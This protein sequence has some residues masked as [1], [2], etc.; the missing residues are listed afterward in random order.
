MEWCLSWY[1]QLVPLQNKSH[2]CEFTRV[3]VPDSSAKLA[4]KH[5]LSILRVS[6]VIG[7]CHGYHIS[8]LCLFFM[9]LPVLLIAS[10]HSLCRSSDQH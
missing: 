2:Q 10:T 3:S 6:G 8:L 5:P 1:H 7:G 4:H 9:S